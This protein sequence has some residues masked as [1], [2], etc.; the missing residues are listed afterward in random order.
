MRQP[1]WNFNIRVRENFSREVD[2]IDEG[3]DDGEGAGHARLL[4]RVEHVLEDQVYGKHV[5][6]LEEA[7]DSDPAIDGA[8]PRKQAETL[9]IFL[10][11]QYCLVKFYEQTAHDC[12]KYC[13]VLTTI[14]TTFE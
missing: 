2:L 1:T 6:V 14:L 8:V 13:I 9:R 7:A 10:C 3:G 4:P 5:H 12:G 11:G